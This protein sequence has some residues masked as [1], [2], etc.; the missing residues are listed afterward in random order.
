MQNPIYGGVPG[1][2]WYV[3]DKVHLGSAKTLL[4]QASSDGIFIGR[5]VL[6]KYCEGLLDAEERNFLESL[7]SEVEITDDPTGDK[8]SYFLNYRADGATQSYDRIVF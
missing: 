5:Y 2:S 3:F 1:P 7:I 4:E 8:K 6:V